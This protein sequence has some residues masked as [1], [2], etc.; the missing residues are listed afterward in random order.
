MVVLGVLL[1]GVTLKY[2]PY[3]D[4]TTDESN[5]KRWYQRSGANRLRVAIDLAVLWTYICALVAVVAHT[6]S[7][8]TSSDG[9]PSYATNLFCSLPYPRLHLF[10][11]SARGSVYRR[12]ASDHDDAHSIAYWC[13]SYYGWLPRL[14]AYREG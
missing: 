8:S 10:F 3:F 9:T 6:S 11:T 13:P 1:L 2:P 7:T 12:R 14:H 5:S 4:D